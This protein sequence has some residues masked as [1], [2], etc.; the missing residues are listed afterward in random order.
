MF[1]ILSDEQIV[2]RKRVAIA[3]YFE[4]GYYEA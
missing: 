3:I 4:I 1:L 2:L